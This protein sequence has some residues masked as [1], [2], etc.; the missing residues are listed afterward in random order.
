MRFVGLVLLLSVFL[1]PAGYAA[2]RTVPGAR[3]VIAN[4]DLATVNIGNIHKAP[5]VSGSMDWTCTLRDTVA[6]R[7]DSGNKVTFCWHI[8]GPTTLRNGYRYATLNAR[9]EIGFNFYS[10][11][12]R[13]GG[14]GTSQYNITG[15]ATRLDDL[16]YSVHS[17]ITLK[18]EG[19][20]AVTSL[21]EGKYNYNNAVTHFTIHQI[22][23]ND[24]ITN[25]NT[26]GSATSDIGGDPNVYSSTSVTINVKTYCNIASVSD[27]V[28]PRQF[29]LR[30]AVTTTANVTVDCSAGTDFAV[31]LDNGLNYSNN[32]RHMINGTDAV[33]YS[34]DPE[35][36]TGL[37]NGL[38]AGLNYSVIGTIPAQAT[39]PIGS[40]KDTIVVT[41]S[42]IDTAA[43]HS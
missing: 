2:N 38:P 36:W 15:I 11:G 20:D 18:L 27:M 29:S 26:C 43:R 6:G 37:G 4:L 25:P 28:F 31:S 34:L 12:V 33:S 8:H 3:C 19:N 1:S 41:V 14:L 24:A 30:N 7:I 40:Y 23:E 21:A 32:T 17:P 9:N 42:I 39:P 22:G 13:V 10:D 5:D 16:T 35:T